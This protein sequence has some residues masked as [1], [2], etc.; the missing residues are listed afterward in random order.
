MFARRHLL[1]FGPAMVEAT[2]RL[3]DTWARGAVVD[4]SAEMSNPLFWLIPDFEKW[5]TPN[6]RR[7]EW[8]ESHLRAVVNRIITRRGP[9]AGSADLLDMLLGTPMSPQQVRDELMT[10]PQAG[11]ET[12]A[13]ALTWTLYLLST[14][15]EARHRLESE[16]DEVPPAAHPPQKTP[17]NS[18]GPPR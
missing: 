8:A 16:V 15:P 17:T 1:G 11:H 12:T 6:R 9:S 7:A 3:L 4:I 18:S 14:H 13:N 2:T 10:F 5:R